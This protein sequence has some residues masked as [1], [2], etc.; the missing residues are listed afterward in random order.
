[1]FGRV[2]EEKWASGLILHANNR[3]KSKSK[4]I[5]MNFTPTS[6]LPLFQTFINSGV[7][8]HI[9]RLHINSTCLE[10]WKRR[11]GVKVHFYTFTFYFYCDYLHAK[12]ILKPTSPLPLFHSSKSSLKM[13]IYI[14]KKLKLTHIHPTPTQHTLAS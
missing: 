1:M 13:C 10:E 7:Y 4:C 14:Y 11:S 8:I 3:N 2:E 5:E 6:S 12:S 9:K